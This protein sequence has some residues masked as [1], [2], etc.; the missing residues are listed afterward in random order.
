[1]DYLK[2]K[3][4]KSASTT[5]MVIRKNAESVLMAQK[6]LLRKVKNLFMITGGPTKAI[7]TLISWSLVVLEFEQFEETRKLNFSILKPKLEG[8]CQSFLCQERNCN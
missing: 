4:A 8:L 2:L 3:T 6:G 7:Q 1:M 5:V